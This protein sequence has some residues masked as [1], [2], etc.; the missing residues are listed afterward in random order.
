ML[1]IIYNPTAGDGKSARFCD[2]I[3]PRLQELQVPYQLH[4]THHKR[5]AAEIARTLTADGQAHTIIAM[6]GDGTIHEVLNGIQDPAKVLFGILPA[7][8]GNDFAAVAEIPNDPLEA[9][10]LILNGTPKF[11]DYMVCSG[12]RGM[13]VIGT[14]FDVDVLKCCYKFKRLRGKLKYLAATILSLIHFEFYRFRLTHNGV[15][16]EHEGFLVC[17]GNGKGIGG[18]LRV[19]PDAVLDDGLMDFVFVDKIS[20]WQY[21]SALFHLVT[22]KLLQLPYVY[23]QQKDCVSAQFLPPAPV[24]ID[25]EIYEDLAFDIHIVHNTLRMFRP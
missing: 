13:N 9:L 5:H 22:G 15:E 6:G 24:E 4:G 3:V 14:G 21:P 12:I 19:C 25:G 7:G 18:G 11:T 1:H 23:L 20:V 10:D 8:S 17:A 2:V 16:E